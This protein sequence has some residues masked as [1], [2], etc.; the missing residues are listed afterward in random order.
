MQD[1][2]KILG[3]EF[4]KRVSNYKADKQIVSELQAIHLELFGANFRMNCSSCLI[5][6]FNEIR[7]ELENDYQPT[8]KIMGQFEIKKSTGGR[9]K[10]IYI[11]NETFTNDN[12]TDEISIDILKKCPAHI[13][14]F[15]RY[16]ENWK[17]LT[18]HVGEKKS[19]VTAPAEPPI[20]LETVEGARLAD[21]PVKKERK[22]RGP[23]KKK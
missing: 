19:K 20:V 11:D 4:A 18:G 3:T 7:I 9:S 14:T 22:R 17:E 5:K 2:G 13:V 8:K 15:E 21:Q 23:K 6:A 12:I 1:K 10:Q 16:P